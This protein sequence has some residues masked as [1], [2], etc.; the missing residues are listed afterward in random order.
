M[1]YQLIGKPLGLEGALGIV[2]E[3][4][5]IVDKEAF[6]NIGE[7]NIE[8]P[9][10]YLNMD[11][12][13]NL[14]LEHLQ[15][16]SRICIVWD[17]DADGLTSGAVM[18]QYINMISRHVQVGEG[19]VLDIIIHEDKAHGLDEL[20]MNK[21]IEGE[22]NLVIL[23]DASSND[24]SQH[25][26]LK[27]MD[28]DIL[29]LDHHNAETISSEA[30]VI[31]N[32][33]SPG[34]ANKAMTGVGVV[35]KFCQ[36]MDERIGVR[37]A[38]LFLDL[39]AIGMIADSADLRDLETRYLVYEGLELINKREN[40]N[41]QITAFVDSMAYSLGNEVTI[42]GVAFYIAPAINAVIRAGTMEE[43]IMLCRGLSNE[44][45]IIPTKIRGQ[46]EL[47]D[48]PLAEAVA[49]MCASVKRRQDSAVKKGV[50]AL[51]AQIEEYGLDNDFILMVNATGIL[52]K[53]YTGLVANKLAGQYER[54]CLVLREVEERVDQETGEVIES[55]YEFGGSARGYDKGSAIENFQQWCLDTKYF[56]FASGHDNSFG[57]GIGKNDLGI[58]FDYVRSLNGTVNNEKVEKV[59]IIF[60]EK[61]FSKTIVETLGR[62]SNIWGTTVYEP[63]YAMEK[64]VLAS[65][66][67]K[68]IGKNKNTL[69]FTYKGVDFI[70]F[71]VKEEEFNTLRIGDKK[72][73]E[74]TAIGKF[75]INEFNGNS[76]PQ[77][78][79]DQ[80][81]SVEKKAFTFG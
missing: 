57:V 66:D 44:D 48:L 60:T 43:K 19:A 52:D 15:K 28:V 38:D 51:N 14:L 34:V 54:P 3:N 50:E 20:T 69:K 27:G 56:H 36:V 17:C 79:I 29:V 10:N 21:V 75:S 33:L 31:N 46:K 64:M 6:F 30:V 41:K 37:Y 22:Y 18:Y 72:T 1:N 71:F 78:A 80:I 68:L 76:T 58:L 65:D 63:K 42:I 81:E 77:V 74:L 2:M 55:P 49:R 53:N 73:L 9:H 5:G 12:G 47:V 25:I 70:K 26:K 23:P 4:R 32:Q 16:G 35:Y 45:E 8:S 61:N 7:W 59:D 11:W 13:V 67:L 39:V 24:Y 62:L 40:Y